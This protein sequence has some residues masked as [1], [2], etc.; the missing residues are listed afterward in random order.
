MSMK[1]LIFVVC[2]CLPLGMFLLACGIFILGC[3]SNSMEFCLESGECELA[4]DV[5]KVP[6]EIPIDPN[7]SFWT[8][9]DH[10]SLQT[11]E[12]GP[13]MITNPKWPDPSVK[14]VKIAGVQNELEIGFLLEWNDPSLEN[15]IEVSATHT[16]QAAL[17]FPLHPKKELPSITMGSENEIVNIWQWRAL[18][19]P[20]LSVTSENRSN[21]SIMEV[22]DN[23]RRSPV[24]DLTAAG[25]ST[26][27]TQEEQD[28][29]GRGMWQGK[30]WR[31]V[32]KRTLVN[33][34]NADV[35]F[36]YSTVMAIAVW[37]GGNRERNGQKGIS[38]WILLRLL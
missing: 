23:Y 4:V 9:T 1:R 8:D 2:G 22:P 15:K 35:Q 34:D 19:E 33:S 18:W 7:A 37:N 10:F 14:S 17:M 36:K 3:G 25:F 24:E 6:G 28:V 11:V 38:D 30:T 13:Q 29:L 31:V 5:V 32:F 27:T 16:D 12:L 20:A 21:R 26:L